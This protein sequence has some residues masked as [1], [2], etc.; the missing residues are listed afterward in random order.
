VAESRLNDGPS[1]GDL[2]VPTRKGTMAVFKLTLEGWEI[3]SRSIS[4][5]GLCVWSSKDVW[6]FGL[7]QSKKWKVGF[8]V[9]GWGF[10]LPRWILKIFV[11]TTWVNMGCLLLWL[12][13]VANL[14]PGGGGMVQWWVWGW[15]RCANDVMMV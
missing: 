4:K 10:C 2:P 12:L 5:V 1:G 8:D 6:H 7:I 13:V 9:Y 11:L 15:W 14:G 3:S